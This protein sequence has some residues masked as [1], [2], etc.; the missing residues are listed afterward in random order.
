[1]NLV[2]I[3]IDGE[4]FP[5]PPGTPVLQVAR[6]NGIYIPHLCY[7]EG[8]PAYGGCRLCLVEV[9]GAR[10][11]QLSC[12]TPAT[13][14]M[15]VRTKTPA[16]REMQRG[17]LEFIISDHPNRC[18]TC[19]RLKHCPAN[20][21]CLRDSV[22]TDRCVTCAKNGHCELQAACDFLNMAGYM[23]YDREQQVL[24][25]AYKT[26]ERVNPLIERDY[27]KCIV[28]ARCIRVC[29]EVREIRAYGLTYR[30]P[31]AQVDTVNGLPLNQT[32]CEFCG[33]CVDVC[34]VESLMDKP[35]KWAGTPQRFATTV[36][37]Y[38]GVGCE[39]RL[40]IRNDRI[41][42][43]HAADGPANHG[44]ACI[45]GHFGM[46]FIHHP[47][48]LTTPLVRKNGELVPTSWDEALSLVAATFARHK[49]DGFAAIASGKATN[50]DNYVIQ[51]LTRAVMS[52]NNI[53]HCARL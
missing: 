18:L 36:C 8:L 41:I 35:A 6:R 1:M 34:P 27:N 32:D 38:C 16:L 24:E 20:G 42:R 2:T 43:L 44:Q 53:D 31:A 9:E 3:T 17:I 14:G 25:K 10:E 7:L 52:T 28:C 49:G 11:Y 26:V 13:Q 45:K 51:K 48:R 30:G 39:L 4:E 37:N 5:V 46:D 50:E 12:S 19:H 23:T 15:V 47:D 22:V 33:A 40:E 29:D 21:V